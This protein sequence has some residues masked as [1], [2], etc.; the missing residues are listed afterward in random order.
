M[1]PNNTTVGTEVKAALFTAKLHDTLGLL[2]LADAPATGAKAAWL[3]KL[4]LDPGPDKIKCVLPAK[5]F[6][7]FQAAIRSATI[8]LGAL[9]VDRNGGTAVLI[10]DRIGA[11]VFAISISKR[12]VI[13]EVAVNNFEDP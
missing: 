7:T 8:R 3:D 2:A 4:L 6:Q 5:Y 1:V 11:A 10:R 12:L 9:P 13:G